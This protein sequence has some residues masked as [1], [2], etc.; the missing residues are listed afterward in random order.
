MYDAHPSFVGMGIIEKEG[1]RFDGLE[2]QPFSDNAKHTERHE[3]NWDNILDIVM[4]GE[5]YELKARART[6]GNAS[7]LY[8]RHRDDG[9]TDTVVVSPRSGKHKTLAVVSA[10]KTGGKG[11]DETIR[12]AENIAERKTASI[13]TTGGSPAYPSQQRGALTDTEAVMKKA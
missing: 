4:H 6:T 11:I 13:Q 5:S 12:R 3:D 7:F 1:H 2:L 10:W 9:K 8:Y